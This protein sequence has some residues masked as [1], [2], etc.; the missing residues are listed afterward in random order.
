[1][2]EKTKTPSER[3]FWLLTDKETLILIHSKLMTV[4]LCLHSKHNI[5]LWIIF[6]A[7]MSC[8]FPLFLCFF[9][10]VWTVWFLFCV[11][12]FT[13]H[14]WGFV[15]SAVCDFFVC[16][17]FVSEISWQLL[18]R[19]GPNSH[20][21]HVWSLGWTTLNVKVKGQGHQGQNCCV[22]AIDSAL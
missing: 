22:I 6:W 18:N 16:F 21:R 8:C 13:T 9:Y 11:T 4:E 1:M 17:L 12:I 10:I 2:L 7:V 20:G 3:Y 14:K 5:L 19:F 15:F